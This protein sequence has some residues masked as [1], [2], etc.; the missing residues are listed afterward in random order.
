MYTS[1]G[2][3]TSADL[4]EYRQDT[5]WYELNQRKPQPDECE[6]CIPF[7]D[8]CDDCPLEDETS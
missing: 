1:H 7:T 5:D 6:H 8:Y 4:E 2:L 3:M